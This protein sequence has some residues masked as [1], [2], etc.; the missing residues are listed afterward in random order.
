MEEGEEGWPWS[1]GLE[2]AVGRRL[3]G[4]VCGQVRA[5]R[6]LLLVA[7]VGICFIYTFF[8]TH[9]LFHYEEVKAGYLER[10]DP[11]GGKAAGLSGHW[12][13]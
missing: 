5:H 11:D 12:A 9:V 3:S 1:C 8:Y 6:C 2:R 10:V 13:A 4:G 7:V